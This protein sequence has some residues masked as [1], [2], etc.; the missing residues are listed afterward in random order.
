MG[1]T[2][3]FFNYKKKEVILYID[4]PLENTGRIA[5]ERIEYIKSKGIKVVNSLEELREVLK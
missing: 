4:A 3:E 5:S 2:L 1:Q